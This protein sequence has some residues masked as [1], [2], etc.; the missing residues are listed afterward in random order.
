MSI[1]NL[2]SKKDLTQATAAKIALGDGVEEKGGSTQRGGV[3]RG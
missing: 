2:A 3:A 1:N